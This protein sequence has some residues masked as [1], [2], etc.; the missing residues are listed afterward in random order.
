MPYVAPS[1]TANEIDEHVLIVKPARSSIRRPSQPDLL[2]R[3]SSEDCSVW[4]TI[5][6]LARSQHSGVRDYLINR[7][8]EMQAED[9]EFFLP[10][11]W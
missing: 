10:Q 1:S 6:H 3:L 9:V 8:Y 4:T 7:M 11:L 2:A 5:L